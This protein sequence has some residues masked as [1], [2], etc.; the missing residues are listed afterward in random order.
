MVVIATAR[1]MTFGRGDVIELRGIPKQVVREAI[2]GDC[3]E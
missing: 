1:R 2:H 3:T